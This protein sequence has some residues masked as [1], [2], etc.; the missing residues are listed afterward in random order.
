MLHRQQRL[1][2]ARRWSRR[3]TTSGAAPRPGAASSAARSGACGSACSSTPWTSEPKVAPAGRSSIGDGRSSPSLGGRGASAS[4]RLETTRRSRLRLLVDRA[5]D[6]RLAVDAAGA[7]APRRGSARSTTCAASRC[8]RPRSKRRTAS[9]SAARSPGSTADAALELATPRRASAPRA[10]HSVSAAVASTSVGTAATAS[11][12]LGLAGARVRSS[13]RVS[14]AWPA[15][16][17]RRPPG[18]HLGL[19]A[20]ERDVG[21]PELL[22][23]RSPARARRSASG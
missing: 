3:P 13:S 10:C 9:R 4:E 21:Q 8:R 23:R 11:G 18:D 22:A 20:G 2:R 15:F 7:P 1:G 6:L 14:P 19:G 5:L 17:A 12:H 16:Q